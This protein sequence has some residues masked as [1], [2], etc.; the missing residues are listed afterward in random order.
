MG[1]AMAGAGR[2][3]A[4]ARQAVGGA[5]LFIGYSTPADYATRMIMLVSIAAGL[6]AMLLPAPYSGGAPP[7]QRR[8]GDQQDALRARRDGRILPV[9]E[10]ERRVVPTMRGAQYLGFDF[11]PD[12]G[13]YTLKFLRDGTVIW[14]DVDGRSGRIIGRTGN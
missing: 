10:I 11:D 12:A 8:H 9:P 1:A 2:A 5:G 3:R 7:P 13:I 4:A 6:L 14:I